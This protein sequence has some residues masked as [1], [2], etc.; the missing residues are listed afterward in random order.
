MKLENV[1]PKPADPL[2]QFTGPSDGVAAKDWPGRVGSGVGGVNSGVPD[3]AAMA[4]VANESAEITDPA[5]TEAR[6]EAL[7]QSYL[8]NV[9][10]PSLLARA[11]IEMAAAQ[12]ENAVQARADARSQ[13]KT[14]HLAAAGKSEDAANK[15][16]SGAMK[17]LIGGLVGS[18]VSLGFAGFSTYI[19]AKSGIGSGK[20]NKSEEVKAFDG[21]IAQLQGDL[22]GLSKR[23]DM[24][25]SGADPYDA[26]AGL[27]NQIKFTESRLGKVTDARN[28]ADAS[29]LNHNQTMANTQSQVVN[30]VGTSLSGATTATTTFGA[31]TDE[32]AAEIDRAD[33]QRIQA[34]GTDI[35]NQQDQEKKI[36]DDLNGII[37][38]AIQFLKDLQDS[39]I[40]R[41]EII[42][43]MAG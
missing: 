6:L 22:K 7:I 16:E 1:S 11:L 31:K 5:G 27:N 41:M 26:P 34:Q 32:A 13:V 4:V 37:Q 35:D 39:E 15:I 12:R 43:R 10:D 3:A 19:Q 33:G 9:R 20:M 29:R 2:Q 8:T 23:F 28:A 14:Q 36:V 24:A 42:G 25:A 30:S 40:K 18:A 17:N 38:A 21:E